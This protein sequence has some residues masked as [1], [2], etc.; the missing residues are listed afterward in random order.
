MY[1]LRS[2][3]VWYFTGL[4]VGLGV[5][6]LANFVVPELSYIINIFTLVG[7]YLIWSGVNPKAPPIIFWP[8]ITLFCVIFFFFP[9]MELSHQIAFKQDMAQKFQEWGPSAQHLIPKVAETT[10][11]IFNP[12]DP[13]KRELYK[14]IFYMLTIAF[15]GLFAIVQNLNNIRLNSI[16]LFN[17]FM[18]SYGCLALYLSASSYLIMLTMMGPSHRFFVPSLLHALLCGLLVAVMIYPFA[19]GINI[20]VTKVRSH[21]AL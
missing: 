14:I 3:W 13:T 7:G 17:G 21:H 10:E 6:L 20:I 11:S 18:A 15:F 9:M 1:L 19:L 5:M 4:V 8:Y 2:G 12:R 16:N